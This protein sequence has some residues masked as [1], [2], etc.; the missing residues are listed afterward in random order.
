VYDDTT[1][2]TDMNQL[3]LLYT[4]IFLLHNNRNSIDD[5]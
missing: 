3:L 5:D 4:S 2:R 1:I